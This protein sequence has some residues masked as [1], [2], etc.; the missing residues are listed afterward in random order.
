MHSNKSQKLRLNND[1][2]KKI[3]LNGFVSLWQCCLSYSQCSLVAEHW[4][5]VTDSNG[6]PLIGA[7]ITVKNSPEGTVSDVDGNYV[8]YSEKFNS[9]DVLVLPL[10]SYQN[11]ETSIRVLSVRRS[12]AFSVRSI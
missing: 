10:P 11:Q 3:H 8:L 9:K 4:G 12:I 5:K 2:T 1:E 6:D 7:T